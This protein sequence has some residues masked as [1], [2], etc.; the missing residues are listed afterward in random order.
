MVLKSKYR[1]RIS[2]KT[3]SWA[4][5]IIILLIVVAFVHPFIANERPL[6]CK[7]EG[8][9]YFP[10][11]RSVTTNLHLTRPYSKINDFNWDQKVYEFK[12]MPVIPY[13]YNTIDTR[14]SQYKSPFDQQNVENMWQRH[15]LGTDILGRDVFAG[16]LKG[17]EISVKIG[18][19]S[20][21][22]ATIIALFFGLGAAF[23]LRF[24]LKLDVFAII[25]LLVSALI[26][27]YFLWLG[28]NTSMVTF[29]ISGIICLV[30]NYGYYLLKKYKRIKIAEKYQ[31]KIP[32]DGIFMRLIEAMKAIPSF[33]FL[34]AAISI[35][36]TLSVVG[37]IS[38]LAFI[39]WPGLSRFIRA[40]AL[41]ILSQDYITAAKAYGASDWRIVKTHVLPK[42]ITTLSVVLAFGISSAIIAESTL[43]FLGIGISIDQVSWGS[44]LNEAKINFSAW[45]LAIFPGL[46]LFVLILSL[47]VLGEEL[48]IQ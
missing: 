4:L 20:V 25:L 1:K 10:V 34:L 22:L 38:I 13:S 26:L 28:I 33:I 37:L 46:A 14:N 43:S 3:K 42:L 16:I 11:F 9:H 30:L 29:W 35:F 44:L 45:W 15:W 6:Y 17:T 47:N 21:I 23:S 41:K 32:I 19:I 12:I 39:M 7:I 18:F 36:K 2:S 5:K 8:S 24:P 31:F 48:E 40:E 27:V